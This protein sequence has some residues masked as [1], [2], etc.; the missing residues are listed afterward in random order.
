MIP[1]PIE[2]LLIT[3]SQQPL[4]SIAVLVGFW[5][6]VMRVKTVRESLSVSLENN[7]RAIA[8]FIALVV[9]TAFVGFAVWYAEQ[10]GFACEVEPQVATVSCLLQ[11]GEALYH[12]T[13]AAERYSILYGPSLYLVTG[14]LFKIFGPSIP[15][16][17]AG[18][19]FALIAAMGLI[20][21]TLLRS[22]RVNTALVLTSV[23][24]LMLWTTGTSPF[25]LRPDPFLI[26]GAALGLFGAGLKQRRTAV[27]LVAIAIGFSVNLKIHA[28]LYMLPV[29]ALLDLRH[30]W[31]HVLSAVGLGTALVMAP[32]A[33]H[34]GIDPFL[35]S[36][37]SKLSLQHGLQPEV[38]PLLLRRAL[39]F[40][41]PMLIP[42]ALGGRLSQR[43]RLANQLALAWLTSNLTVIVLAT[44][45]GAGLVHLLP[46]VPVNIVYCAILWNSLPNRS[47]SWS[48]AP[49]AWG[50]GAVAAF[51]V[52]VLIF[53]SVVGYR[54]GRRAEAI[55]VNSEQLCADITTILDERGDRTVGMGYGG[56]GYSFVAT[57]L[58]PLLAFAQQPVT[59]DAISQ[60]DAQL[61]NL[62]M[63]PESMASLDAGVIDVWLIP[64]DQQ[65]FT[66]R[67]WYAP[68]ETI[69]SDDFRAHFLDHYALEGHS[70][71]FDLWTWQGQ[72]QASRSGRIGPSAP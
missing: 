35:Y 7:G 59:I 5:M 25:V 11:D 3:V 70:E 28:G 50:R 56:E 55:M 31:K 44:K 42:L 45:P 17:K 12:T 10:P 27:L 34:P 6:L 47:T 16:A 54:S 20:F 64:R 48:M 38:L 53:G 30:G 66:K 13:D 32:F 67:S 26:F 49:A 61:A 23:A 1:R 8:G 33:F 39:F 4:V 63:S 40:A 36:E 9:L 43:P 37:W 51:L 46:L 71:F 68:H 65:P 62:E 22:V 69:F 72:R 2:D 15:L 60:M 58:R 41:V 14:A 57:Y 24:A 18:A 52:T 29:L 19:V 21:T